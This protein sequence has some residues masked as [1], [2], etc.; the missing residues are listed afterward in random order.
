VIGACI[1]GDMACARAAE[2]L[3]LSVRHIK[4][5]KKRLREAQFFKLRETAIVD[6]C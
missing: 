2:L 5:L 3:C 1:K 4:R 6:A